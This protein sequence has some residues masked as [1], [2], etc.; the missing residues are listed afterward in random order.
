M[1][2]AA[3]VKR[4][5]RA[6]MS[7]VSIGFV[8]ICSPS[9]VQHSKRRIC[10]DRPGIRG[11]GRRRL[12]I[13]AVNNGEFDPYGKKYVNGGSSEGGNGDEP[14]TDS[15]ESEVD[16]ALD[17]VED[18]AD[19]VQS[20]MED[21]VDSVQEGAD[22][23]VESGQEEAEVLATELQEGVQDVQDTVEEKADEVAEQGEKVY[24][25][26]KMRNESPEELKRDLFI[27]VAGTNR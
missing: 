4:I 7:S 5:L 13:V 22:D 1:R 17:T 10:A 25:D 26:A 14:K 12:T 24:I 8:G 3:K 6:T 19:D 21:A 16:E 15:A 2:T 11:H 9:V 27:A 23:V 20:N 18:V